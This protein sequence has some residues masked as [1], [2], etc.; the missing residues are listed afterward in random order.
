MTEESLKIL[1]D[2][3]KN[4][5][6]SDL[7]SN[8]DKMH[9]KRYMI[10]K[11]LYLFRKYQYWSEKRVSCSGMKRKKAKYLSRYYN[12]KAN[13]YSEKCGVEIGKTSVIGKNCDIWHSG[14]VI[15]GTIGSGCIFHG[16][17][18]IGNKGK[19]RS[20]ETPTLGDN[21][22][23]GAGAVIIGKIRIAD[24][25]IIGSNAVV[26]KDF[27]EEGSVIAGVPAKVIKNGR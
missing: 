18:I 14:V 2:E 12:R 19:G 11:Y 17:N 22:D 15:N 20:D 13:D 27:L 3:E 21:V 4:F 9:H 5:Y 23:V 7:S 25:C 24:N 10:W 6:F 16:N 8:A 1:L 26:T